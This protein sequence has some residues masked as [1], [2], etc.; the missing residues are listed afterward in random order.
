MKKSTIL[1]I[2][3]VILAFFI[4]SAFGNR[5]KVYD[6]KETFKKPEDAIVNFI[7]YINTYETVK[8]DNNYYEVASTNFLESISKRYRLYV[9][10][11]DRYRSIFEQVPV[12]F[13]YDIEEVDYNSLI[14]IKNNYENSFNNIVNYDR[15]SNPKAYKLEGYGSRNVDIDK[16]YVKED[17]TV[18]NKNGN[19]EIPL[20]LYL[21]VV[22]EGEGYV[23]DYY[24]VGYK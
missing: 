17:G 13:S 10:I 5:E 2:A 16:S 3:G 11:K 23:V 24:S 9:G 8:S 6:K 21:I 22:N 19:E 12:L 14:N 20:T 7:G 1:A 15:D 18:N 4:V